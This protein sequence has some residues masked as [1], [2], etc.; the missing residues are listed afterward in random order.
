MVSKISELLRVGQKPKVE[1]IPKMY[2]D[3][4]SYAMLRKKGGL[5]CQETNCIRDP[6]DRP[7]VNV[8]IKWR[9]FVREPLGMKI[10]RDGKQDIRASSCRTKAEGGLWCQE[11]NCIRDPNDRPVVNVHFWDHF[12]LR[13]L[14]R[15]HESNGES[16]CGSL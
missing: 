3:L 16:L 5:W 10:G 12:N 4:V 15:S 2:I 13:L 14:A 7:V 6:N 11:T 8:H 1:M 9:I